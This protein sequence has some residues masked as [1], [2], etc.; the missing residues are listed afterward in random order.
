MNKFCAVDTNWKK[1]F[2]IRRGSRFSAS[3]TEKT[4]K[5]KDLN[6]R[7]LWTHERPTLVEF[8]RSGPVNVILLLKQQTITNITFQLTNN[9]AGQSTSKV[10]WLLSLDS[11]DE[12][13]NDRRPLIRTTWLHQTINCRSRICTRGLRTEHSNTYRETGSDCTNQ[14]ANRLGHETRENC[15]RQKLGVT[16]SFV[17]LICHEVDYCTVNYWKQNLRRDE[18]KN[19]KLT[20]QKKC[21]N[22]ETELKHVFL[23]NKTNTGAYES[24]VHG[25]H[26]SEDVAMRMRSIQ[27]R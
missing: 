3:A 6:Q 10:N 15:D 8:D 18:S 1:T 23:V 21:S 20:Q 2:Y 24:A 7:K 5:G 11:K 27:T 14:Q 26:C 19:R 9:V 12:F 4:T 25:C 17:G 16:Q 22:E 13:T